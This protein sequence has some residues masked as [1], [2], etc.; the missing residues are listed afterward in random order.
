ML[1]IPGHISVKRRLSAPGRRR[2]IG[3]EL[4]PESMSNKLDKLATMSDKP[5]RKSLVSSDKRINPTNCIPHQHSVQAS[6]S[7]PE[8][9]FVGMKE[10]SHFHPGTAP[11]KQLKLRATARECIKSM[12]SIVTKQNFR[13]PVRQAKDGEKVFGYTCPECEHFAQLLRNENVKE[14]VIRA[15]ST[16]KYFCAPT[17]SPQNLWEPWNIDS[18][19][20]TVVNEPHVSPDIRNR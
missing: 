16:H 12:R 15:A 5:E 20:L 11:P 7:E 6:I 14:S 13:A 19:P 9:A 1:T 18:S 8:P 3:L 10:E 17:N 2:S 4:K